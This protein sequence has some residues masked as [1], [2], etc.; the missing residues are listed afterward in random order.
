MDVR[1]PSESREPAATGSTARPSKSPRRTSAARGGGTM[2]RDVVAGRAVALTLA[3]GAT[4]REVGAVLGIAAATRE[5]LV[6]TESAR[7]GAG[8]R[9]TPPVAASAG[10]SQSAAARA[11]SQAARVTRRG[12]AAASAP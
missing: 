4:L 3:A 10:E 5:L 1:L 12:G 8:L 2:A 6:L 7:A 11:V 9:A